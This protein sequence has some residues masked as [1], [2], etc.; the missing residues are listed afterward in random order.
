MLRKAY[1]RTMKLAAH[2][3]ALWWLSVVSFVESSV[4]P[5]PPD[6][7]LIPMTL[8]DRRRAWWYA[9]VC[10]VS[11]VVGGF[12]GYAIGYWLFETV[13]RAIID[14]YHLQ[15]KFAA[16]QETFN[17]YGGWIVL[18]K[19]MTPIPYKLITITAGVT[20][21]DLV[22]FTLASLGSRAI[23]FFLVAGL[24]WWFGDPIREFIER[25]LALVTTLFLV[26]LVGGFLILKVL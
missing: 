24:L 6:V 22:V 12:L 19:G 15:T 18:A 8:A 1:D 13:G 21:L 14:F 2:R 3:H 25:R 16:F 4:F 20:K 9:A 23:R 7:L 10:T 26:F 5:I 11:S 17:H